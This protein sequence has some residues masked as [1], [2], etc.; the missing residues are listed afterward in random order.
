MCQTYRKSIIA[1]MQASQ[2]EQQDTNPFGSAE[3]E[4]LTPRSARGNRSARG[5]PEDHFEN[6]KQQIQNLQQADDPKVEQAP[7][8]EKTAPED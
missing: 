1:G 3:P 7:K 4:T 2:E 6:L 8:E 5:R